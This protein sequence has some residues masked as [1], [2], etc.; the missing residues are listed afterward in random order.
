MVGVM[1]YVRLMN[2]TSVPLKQIMHCTL[3]KNKGERKLSLKQY[4]EHVL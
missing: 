2:H 3:I 1:N 4:K